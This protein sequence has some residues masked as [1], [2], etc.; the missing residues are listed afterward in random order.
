MGGRP[1]S[2][3]RRA[4]HA[5]H[6]RCGDR[7]RL[8]AEE[9]SSISIRSNSRYLRAARGACAVHGQP[10]RAARGHGPHCRGRTSRHLPRQGRS[11]RSSP[12][13][14]SPA[15][16]GAVGRIQNPLVDLGCELVTDTDA[17]VHVTGH[18]RREELKEMYAWVQTAHRHSHAW[19]GA[20]SGR[21]CQACARGWRREVLTSAMAKSSVGARARRESSTRLR[22]GGCSGTGGCSCRATMAR[23]VSADRWR[24]RV[25]WSFGL[26]CRARG[27]L[28]AEPEVVLDGVPAAGRRGPVHARHRARC[29]R[30]H[31]SQYSARPAQDAEM[32]R[33]AVRRAVR[34][35]VEEPGASAHRQGPADAC[36]GQALR[37]AGWMALTP[38]DLLRSRPSRCSTRSS[39]AAPGTSWHSR[40]PAR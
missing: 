24:S 37:L 31:A 17:L 6:H 20:A 29:R 5:P 36:A 8:S 22:W 27:E 3:G 38:F 21:A 40:R 2:G 11:G 25:S 23:C 16:S 18:P 10:G 12:R 9:I 34:A 28:L 19:R 14:L 32:V 13:A 35:A 1:A 7:Y 15:T 39:I 30:R 4:G 26:P 33:E